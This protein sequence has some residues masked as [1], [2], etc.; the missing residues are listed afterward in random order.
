MKC[1][2]QIFLLYG[3]LATSLTEEKKRTLYE[4]DCKKHFRM[5]GTPPALQKKRSAPYMKVIAKNI[6]VGGDPTSFTEEKKRTLYESALLFFTYRAGGDE[7]NR[8]LTTSQ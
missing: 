1:V 2:F 5:V 6:F 8:T 7:G 4:S 3:G